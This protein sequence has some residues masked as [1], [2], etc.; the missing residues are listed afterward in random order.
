MSHQE[1]DGEVLES[2]LWPT[3][4]CLNSWAVTGDAEGSDNL[5]SSPTQAYRFLCWNLHRFWAG[6][7]AVRMDGAWY[8]A[9]FVLS[10]RTEMVQQELHLRTSQSIPKSNEHP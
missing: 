8:C 9:C 5:E 6:V 7:A 10:A 1:G 3:L 4:T 2:E